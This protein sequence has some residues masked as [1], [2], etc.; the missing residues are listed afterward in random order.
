MGP[1][2]PQAGSFK[3][4]AGR[5][6]QG[7]EAR[8]A[9]ASPRD[10]A[11][12]VAPALCEASCNASMNDS[13][14]HRSR[15]RSLALSPCTFAFL[16]ERPPRGGCVPVASPARAPSL[17]WRLTLARQAVLPETIAEEKGGNGPSLL[18]RHG[19]MKIRTEA[20]ASDALDVIGVAVAVARSPVVTGSPR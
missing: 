13:S 11:Y 10:G 19:A 4:L 9:A 18:A 15:L 14:G 20:A 12:V 3:L 2:A 17:W 16:Q 1:L 8:P 6:R 7:R 5:P